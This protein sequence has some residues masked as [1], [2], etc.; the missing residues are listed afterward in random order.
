[1]NTKALA[2]LASLAGPA[3]AET[4]MIEQITLASV[5]S[6]QFVTEGQTGH[7]V[8]T[9]LEFATRE[10]C[11]NFKASAASLTHGVDVPMGTGSYFA[12]VGAISTE[13]ALKNATMP[14]K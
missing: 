9:I 5:D 12:R 14:R 2:L 13:C 10:L 1:M 6:G 3:Y 4:W 11:D 7:P 8:V